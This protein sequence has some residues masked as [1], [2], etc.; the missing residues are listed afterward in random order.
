MRTSIGPDTFTLQA[1]SKDQTIN[2]GRQWPIVQARQKTLSCSYLEKVWKAQQ[3]QRFSHSLM[4]T[5]SVTL[6]QIN[7]LPINGNVPIKGKGWDQQRSIN[8]THLLSSDKTY[9]NGAFERN[10]LP[11]SRDEV[12][13][14]TPEV[15]KPMG[16]V[17]L[18][19]C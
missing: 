10:Q 6:I 11:D 19:P 18:T 9:T 3:L 7:C 13:E 15:W 8:P 16:C 5:S 2:P 14:L 4:S 17:V 1:I 12:L